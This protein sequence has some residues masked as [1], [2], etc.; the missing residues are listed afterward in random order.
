MKAKNPHEEV[1]ETLSKFQAGYT[2]RDTS[3]IDQFMKLFSQSNEIELIGIGASARRA[4]EWFQGTEEVADIIKGD[5]TYWGNVLL[6]IDGAK[7]SVNGETAWLS[8]TGTVTQT[9]HFDDSLSFFLD[10][11]KEMLEDERIDL[12]TRLVE[13]THYGMRRV[14]ERHKGVGHSWPF[15]LTAV[16]VKD[17]DNWLFH[18][19][20]WSMPVE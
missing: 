3:K 8:T 16:L 12:D 6:D 15:V 14:R 19:L 11:M 5:W 18:T 17:S 10:R 9:E 7:I 20:H 2:A 13:S 4:Y 1:R